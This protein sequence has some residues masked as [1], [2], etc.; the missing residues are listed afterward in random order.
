MTS[1]R[2]ACTGWRDGG[3]ID[4][5]MMQSIECESWRRLRPRARAFD[6]ANTTEKH[7][8][9]KFIRK[10]SMCTKM[11]YNGYKLGESPRRSLLCL[12]KTKHL[13]LLKHLKQ[14]EII[15]N[16]LKLSETIWNYLKHLKLSETSETIWNYLKLSETIWTFESSG[17]W[18]GS[19]EYLSMVVVVS[20]WFFY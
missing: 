17:A 10:I 14:S 19:S 3:T 4:E 1:V 5:C 18:D 13:K 7:T 2:K 15:W 20:F 9:K 11:S 16:Y 6:S 12:Y 8:T